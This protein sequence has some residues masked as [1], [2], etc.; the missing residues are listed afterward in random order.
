MFFKNSSELLTLK[1][2]LKI[3]YLF[4]H[5]GCHIPRLDFGKA[6]R[7]LSPR[8]HVNTNSNNKKGENWNWLRRKMTKHSFKK[9]QKF[10]T[11]CFTREDMQPQKSFNFTK[12][13]KLSGE[14]KKVLNEP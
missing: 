8:P 7:H 14:L 1:R 6:I 3:K 2:T 4:S 12:L 10:R 5:I 13:S 9:K 11:N